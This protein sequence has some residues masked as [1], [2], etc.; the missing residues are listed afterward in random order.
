M[1]CWR[2]VVTA[3]LGFVSA[4][5]CATTSISGLYCATPSASPEHPHCELLVETPEGVWVA[6]GE[7]ARLADRDALALR[8][9][10]RR[11]DPWQLD[12]GELF[13][14]TTDPVLEMML[15][16]LQGRRIFY[17]LTPSGEVDHRSMLV[18]DDALFLHTE[19]QYGAFPPEC[20]AGI[21]AYATARLRDPLDPLAEPPRRRAGFIERQGNVLG[22]EY[23]PGACPKTLDPAR[24]NSARDMVA[25]AKVYLR[26]NG[27]I[28]GVK[29]DDLRLG[30]RASNTWN[31]T[32]Y[33][34]ADISRREI[35]DLI[36]GLD[37]YPP[38]E[39]L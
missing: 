1:R 28:E 15:T 27:S 26:S 18:I 23:M 35:H 2:V 8:A 33:V 14:R 30:S 37:L 29:L 16:E 9:P 34:P 12:M 36:V 39:G 19:R 31:S 17:T 5:G 10:A 7:G 22:L 25:V 20:L 13:S 11:N 21:L 6:D 24:Y 4:A 38:I 3:T 32:F